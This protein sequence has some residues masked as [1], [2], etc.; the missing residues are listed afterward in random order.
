MKIQDEDGKELTP[1]EIEELTGGVYRTVR[2]IYYRCKRCG[3]RRSI[4]LTSE[5]KGCVNCGYELLQM[6]VEFPE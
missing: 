1:E 4:G 3:H 2:N 5:D 6:E